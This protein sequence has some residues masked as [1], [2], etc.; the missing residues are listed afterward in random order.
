MPFAVTGLAA[1][2]FWIGLM[3]VELF[4]FRIRLFPAFG[5]GGLRGLDDRE[6]G[7]QYELDDVRRH[8]GEDA[9]EQYGPLISDRE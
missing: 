6:H 5:D 4:S 3:L 2:V 9:V 1:P 7:R 8:G